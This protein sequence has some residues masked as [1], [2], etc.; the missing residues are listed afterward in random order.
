MVRRDAESVMQGLW[1]LPGG[2]CQE[3]EDPEL[4]VVRESRERYG[5]KLEPVREI[6]RVKHHIMNQRITLHAFEASL[7]GA[8]GPRRSSRAWVDP[9]SGANRPV[10]SMTLKVFRALDSKGAAGSTDD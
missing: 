7:K 10:S 6:L 4:A 3:K 5:L 8:L 9:N 2:T 1:E